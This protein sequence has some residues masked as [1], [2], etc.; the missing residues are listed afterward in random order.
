MGHNNKDGGMC[1]RGEEEEEWS[2]HG[3]ILHAG[4]A[5]DDKAGGKPQGNARS[6]QGLCILV[7]L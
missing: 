6:N 2:V 3:G 1:I 4:A 7:G 5:Q